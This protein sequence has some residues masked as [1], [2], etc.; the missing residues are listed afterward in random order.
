MPTVTLFVAI[1]PT[2]F[3]FAVARI[4]LRSRRAHVHCSLFIGWR[5]AICCCFGIDNVARVPAVIQ[6]HFSGGSVAARSEKL[7]VFVSQLA[8]AYP[9]HHTGPVMTDDDRIDAWLAN[10]RLERLE[11]YIKRRRPLAHI[12]FE[13]L[14]TRW[15]ATIRAWERSL[16]EFDH[17]ERED[18]EA[19]MQLRKIKPPYEVVKDQL[20]ALRSAAQK[21]GAQILNDPERRDAIDR[22]FTA[23]IKQFEKRAKGTKN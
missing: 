16:S 9:N 23:E 3:A 12:S 1:V 14:E 15:I 18:I 13:E 20:N 21:V 11:E 10:Q 4:P 17:E 19:E 8:E 22:H 6:S 5:V 7:A 2:F